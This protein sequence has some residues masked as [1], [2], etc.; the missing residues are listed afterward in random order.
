MSHIHSIDG[1]LLIPKGEE[2]PPGYRFKLKP[3]VEPEC[4]TLFE[5]EV[6]KPKTVLLSV[7]QIVKKAE[8]EPVSVWI[9]AGCHEVT[10]IQIPMPKN[11]ERK[12][13]SAKTFCLTLGA[14]TTLTFDIHTKIEVVIK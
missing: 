6:D 4:L 5:I 1:R 10:A 12:A 11:W 3:G 9:A 13:S 8:Y 2:P 14:S 7:S